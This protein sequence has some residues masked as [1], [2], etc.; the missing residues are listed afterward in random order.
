MLRQN[1]RENV[2]FVVYKYKWCP[3]I[4]QHVSDGLAKCSEH[5]SE[6]VPFDFTKILKLSKHIHTFIHFQVRWDLRII[7]PNLLYWEV[8]FKVV[9]LSL[10]WSLPEFC[11]EGLH[12]NRQL[13]VQVWILSVIRV[14]LLALFCL[15][16]SRLEVL[17]NCHGKNDAKFVET[18]LKHE[19]HAMTPWI[20][21]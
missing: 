2:F 18:F 13:G 14:M 11:M 20:T 17:I 5:L 21:V 12:W 7:L 6:N 15:K 4:L 19:A 10:S 9:F 3:K 16:H 1:K 8:T